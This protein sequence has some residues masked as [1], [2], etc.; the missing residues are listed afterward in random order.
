MPVEPA[1]SAASRVQHW[2]SGQQQQ[3]QDGP[4]ELLVSFTSVYPIVKS[5]KRGSGSHT[6][7][8]GASS[9]W[10]SVQGDDYSSLAPR[11]VRGHE[12]NCPCFDYTPVPVYQEVDPNPNPLSGR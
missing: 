5:T 3:Y 4:S 7:G 6:V 8:D 11:Q 9:I 1:A 10:G 12:G 2:V